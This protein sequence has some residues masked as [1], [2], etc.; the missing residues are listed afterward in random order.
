[1]VG[2]F[3]FHISVRRVVVLPALAS[4]LLS[5]ACDGSGYGAHNLLAGRPDC[6]RADESGRGR[7]CILLYLYGPSGEYQRYE[8]GRGGLRGRFKGLVRSLRRV[9]IGSDGQPTGR[10]PGTK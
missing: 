10:D 3:A 6:G 8:H 4:A 2:Y 1:M 9:H 7:G 5:V